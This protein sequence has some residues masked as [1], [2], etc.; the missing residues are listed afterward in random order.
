[1]SWSSFWY[2]LCVIPL[3][4]NDT[5]SKTKENVFEKKRKKKKVLKSHLVYPNRAG[6]VISS[7][8]GTLASSS[9]IM[10]LALHISSSSQS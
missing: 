1:M 3:E 6:K 8:P 2:Y 5:D 7:N 9:D 10:R 4:V